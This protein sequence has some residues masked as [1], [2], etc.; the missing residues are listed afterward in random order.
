M[1]GS[2]YWGQ[3]SRPINYLRSLLW[4]L[5]QGRR[6]H[7]WAREVCTREAD[8]Q[9]RHGL[10]AIL[11]VEMSARPQLARALEWAVALPL[12]SAPQGPWT[13]LGRRITVGPLQL[14]NGAFKRVRA[15][16]EARAVLHSWGGNPRDFEGLAQLWNGPLS[17]RG[18][19]SVRYDDALRLAYPLAVRLAAKVLT[20]DVGFRRHA[21]RCAVGGAED[22]GTASR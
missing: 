6:A 21:I 16:E 18:S 11:L 19:S 17:A 20:E 3:R 5:A 4:R 2:S 13:Q 10:I 1:G 8:E 14:R 9:W 22:E 12:R 15:I 7:R